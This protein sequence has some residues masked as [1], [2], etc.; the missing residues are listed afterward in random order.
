MELDSYKLRFRFA[1]PVGKGLII[2]SSA[3]VAGEVVATLP[4]GYQPT[5]IRYFIYH[6][7]NSYARVQIEPTGQIKV[8]IAG[9]NSTSG[10]DIIFGLG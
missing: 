4:I 2:K 8:T 1:D 9:S 5:Q 10:L 3:L 6:G 7:S